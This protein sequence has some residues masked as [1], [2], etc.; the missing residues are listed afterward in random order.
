MSERLPHL[1]L[2]RSQGHSLI[3]IGLAAAKASTLGLITLGLLVLRV[4]SSRQLSARLA[5]IN[6]N[7]D[8]VV[9]MTLQYDLPEA[10]IAYDPIIEAIERY[11]LEN[12]AYPDSLGALVPGYLAAPPGIYIPAGERLEYH[13]NSTAEGQP[14]FT[15]LVYGHH[16]GLA[17]LHGWE[18][19]YC[20]EEFGFCGMPDDRHYHPH[21]VNQRWIWVNRSAL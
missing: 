14:P 15:F 11:H 12:G 4:F 7:D 5:S 1:H 16:T 6:Q 2:T 20:P 9:E 10:I 3:P 19:R 8:M 21:R 13:A 18:F 17:F